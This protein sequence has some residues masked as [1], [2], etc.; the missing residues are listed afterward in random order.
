ML[1]NRL[2]NVIRRTEYSNTQLQ[3]MDLDLEQIHPWE[4]FSHSSDPRGRL[5]GRL[6][7]CTEAP[8]AWSGR[9]A[10]AALVLQALKGGGIEERSVF[11]VCTKHERLHYDLLLRKKVRL[12]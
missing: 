3:P 7:L 6:I 8:R 5:S 2:P 12:L 1:H 4:S 11:L 9:F 10:L